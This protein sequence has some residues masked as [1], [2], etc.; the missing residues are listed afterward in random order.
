MQTDNSR[1]IRTEADE[2]Q[3]TADRF[4][5]REVRREVDEKQQTNTDSAAERYTADR[6]ADSDRQVQ[7]ETIGQY[8]MKNEAK[9]DEI[10]QNQNMLM[11]R[12]YT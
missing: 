7:T 5:S 1:E 2:E 12:W 4:S 11:L 6:A 10:G 8:P 3:Q 9:L